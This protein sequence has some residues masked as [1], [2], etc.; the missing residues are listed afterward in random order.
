[1]RKRYDSRSG[2]ER[3]AVQ[4]IAKRL[5]LSPTTVSRAL[6]GKGRIGQETKDRIHQFLEENH[7]IPNVSE[8]TQDQEKNIC[9]LLP[10]E[11]EQASLPYFQD[12]LL[13]LYDN[14]SAYGYGV[15]VVKTVS[16]DIHQLKSL[17]EQHKIRGA[18]LTR[19]IEKDLAVSYLKSQKIPFVV[20][21]SLEQEDVLQVDF[22]QERGCRDLTEVLLKMH[23]RRLACVCGDAGHKVTQSRLKGIQ[24]AFEEAKIPFP[25]DLLYT[26][27]IYSSIAEKYVEDLLKKDTECILCLDDNICISVLSVLYK[28]K[29]KVP[30]NVK[31]ASCYGSRLLGLCYPA[32]TCLE[33]DLKEM[34]RL[35]SKKLL[36]AVE[37]T[38]DDTKLILGYNIV[39]KDST[40]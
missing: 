3:I 30:E 34:G 26:G 37:G 17:A 13:N 22:D 8:R 35:A 18:V 4:E 33:F 14:F 23:I 10:G 12:I 40:K 25:S 1:M 21:G 24:T 15:L 9:V 7:Y 16:N 5:E 19:S 36:D 28:K 6:S 38:A 27:A 39:I 31:V 32:V 2:G 20:I 29:I 11:E